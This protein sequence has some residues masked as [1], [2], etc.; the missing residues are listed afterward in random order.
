MLGREIEM[1]E[2]LVCGETLLFVNV[3]LMHFFLHSQIMSIHLLLISSCGVVHGKSILP[4]D[5]LSFGYTLSSVIFS[6]S[7]CYI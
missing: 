6:K 7:M 2:E 3:L 4:L 5:L 1:E